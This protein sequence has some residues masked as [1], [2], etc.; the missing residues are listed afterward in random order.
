MKRIAVLAVAIAAL[1]ATQVNA[2]ETVITG[3]VGTTTERPIGVPTVDNSGD[4]KNN[5]RLGKPIA[6]TIYVN[7]VAKV[8][9]VYVVTRNIKNNSGAPVV[10]TLD[11]N[12]DIC[13]AKGSVD[14]INKVCGSTFSAKQIRKRISQSVAVYSYPIDNR[15]TVTVTAVI[16]A[17]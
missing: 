4:T 7:C 15:S 16:N 1:T 6:T 5:C 9:T 13:I 8:A 17:N 14:F 12:V 10:A 2:V 11:D 3:L